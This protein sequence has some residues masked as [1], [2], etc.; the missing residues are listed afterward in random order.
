M[1]FMTLAG[2]I[3]KKLCGINLLDG[4]RFVGTFSTVHLWQVAQYANMT[5]LN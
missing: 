2:F 5:E 1:T 3:P 4:V